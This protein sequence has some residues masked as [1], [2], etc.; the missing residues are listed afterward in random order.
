M[1]FATFGTTIPAFVLIAYGAML[2]ASSPALAAGLATKPLQTL[3]GLLPD[4]YP[5]PLIAATTLG[6]LSGVVITMYS[7]GLALQSAGVKLPRQ[8]SVVV[9][10]IVLAGLATLMVVTA[11]A[12][13]GDLFRDFATTMAVPTAAWIGI[14]GSEMMIRNRRFDSES[15]LRR[16]G[17]Y[18]DVRWV[19]LAGLVLISVIGFGLTTATVSW[20]SWQGFVFSAVGVPLGGELASTDLG[21]I[22]ALALGIILPLVAGVPAIRRQE[23]LRA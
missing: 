15:L 4:W 10:G 14:F 22:V 11:T 3:A 20:L 23:S 17:V 6:L 5:I 7:G 2:A 12:G 21:V 1:L 16:G 9:V 19:N 8:W 13:I 18:A